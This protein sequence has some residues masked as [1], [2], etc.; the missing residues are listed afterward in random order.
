[1][2]TVVGALYFGYYFITNQRTLL[3]IACI[4]SLCEKKSTAAT[5]EKQTKSEISCDAKAQLHKSNE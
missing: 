2:Y 5:V 1:M 4:G 3:A